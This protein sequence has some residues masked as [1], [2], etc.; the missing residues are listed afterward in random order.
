MRI[1]IDALTVETA[2]ARLVDEVTLT[3]GRGSSSAWSAP[4]AAASRPCCAVSTGRCAP[5]PAR[6]A[7]EAT[8]STP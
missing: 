2:G 8:T 1:D 6:S 3:A 4:T 7:S 5:P